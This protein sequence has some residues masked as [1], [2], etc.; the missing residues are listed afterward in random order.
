MLTSIIIAAFRK[1][2]KKAR[3]AC[4]GEVIMR[5]IAGTMKGR[6][7]KAP[8]GL[9]LR[10]TSDKVK[11]ALFNILASRIEGANLLDLYAGTGS[12]GIDA[13][14]RGAQSVVFVENNKRHFQF[15]KKNL[16]SYP[17]EGR[18]ETF[19][20]AAADFLRKARKSNRSFD[21]IF[22][23][24]PYQSKEIEKI[25]PILQEGDMITTHGLVVIEHFH[26]KSLPETVGNLSFLKKYKYG[27]TI[28]SFYAKK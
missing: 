14:S 17:L 10:P 6:K 9:E 25:L 18:A 4:L 19:A 8:S 3:D 24:P 22:I 23:D 2:R 13:L 11:E 1:T 26:K 15:L 7:L 21:I 28:L 16:A 27:E 20:T 5:I 12:I